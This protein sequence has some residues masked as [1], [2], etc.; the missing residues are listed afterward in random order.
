MRILHLS[1]LH[2]G[3]RIF[4][5]SLIGDQSA[6]L[7]QALDMARSAD[8]TVI[9]GDIY[10]RPV[11]PAE[12]VALLD[13]F[14][15]AMHAQG[16][17]VAIVP[18]NHDSAERV[19][20]GGAL[21]DACGVYIAPAYDGHARRLTLSDEYGPVHVYL[22]PFVKPA[23]V[24]AALG[25]ESIEGYTAALRAAI[26]A[27]EVEPGV[28]SVLVAHQFVTGGTRS[29]SEEVSVGGLD[30]VDADVFA[31]FS[32]VALGHLHA[33]QSLCGGR[34]RYSGAP[35]SYAFSECG[36]V[37]GALLVELGG[38]GAVT[39]RQLPFTPLHAMRRVRGAFAALMDP[40]QRSE[41]YV[42]ITL[43]DEDDLPD[44]VRQLQQVYP[45][46]LQVVY[47][48]ARTR[49]ARADFTRETAA[50]RSPMALFEELF[51]L[52]N[53]AEMTGAQRELLSGMMERIWEDEA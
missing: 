35:L 43:T 22:L 13:G 49:A 44:A 40:A 39:A 32:Y 1:D 29:E 3:K 12:A 53:G 11:P 38:D 45:N 47:D 26:A 28:R 27:M 18:G 4:E 30:N 2:L 14:L 19:A 52:Q 7:R 23:H 24:R 41:D 8:L 21:F 17:P 10:D 36:D 46:V 42:Q 9:A 48:N 50:A 34:V 37:K 20:F 33:A 16:S 51:A 5:A 15:S 31:P 6:I 25:D